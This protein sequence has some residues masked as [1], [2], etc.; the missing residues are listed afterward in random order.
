MKFKILI[1]L[2]ALFCLGCKPKKE[3]SP[4]VWNTK[5]VALKNKVHNQLF[6]YEK[7]AGWQL[8]FNGKTLDGWHLY[9]KADS[10]SLSAWEVKDGLLYCNPV[11]ESR[12]HGDLVTDSVYENYEFKFE[13]KISPRGNS[14]IFINVQERPEILNTYHS[15]P[16]YQLLDSEHMDYSV[17]TKRPG[18]L[19]G[20][21]PQ[22]NTVEVNPT[23][24][25]NTTAIIQQN[26]RVQFF[27]N[28][29]L[30]ATQ[31]F[32]ATDW[33]NMVAN[34]N[35]KQRP[36][37][38]AHTKGKIALQNWYFEVWFRNMKIRKL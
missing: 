34:S 14:G 36:E 1:L 17:P 9:N 26:G 21:L 15:G 35:F 25:W 8:L 23:G 19:Y 10:T 37:F 13:W 32:R 11:D 38:G 24:Q 2:L 31:D 33:K 20:F 7:E 16:E 29:V 22:Q 28:G 6:D 5:Q 12:V 30:T 27:L 3:K 18:C 4:E